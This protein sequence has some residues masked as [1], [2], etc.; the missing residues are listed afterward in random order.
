MVTFD[1]TLP[2]SIAPTSLSTTSIFFL[3]SISLTDPLDIQCVLILFTP[4]APPLPPQCP[5]S[6]H[7]GILLSVLPAGNHRDSEFLSEMAV[8]CPGDGIS[9]GSSL[10]PPELSGG[11][12]S[13]ARFPSLGWGVFD[14]EDTLRAECSA[15][16]YPQLLSQLQDTGQLLTTG[17]RTASGQC[18]EQYRSMV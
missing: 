16:A 4:I 17:G 18:C 6:H 13:S 8:L 9:R 5:L 7:H 2:N 10:L 3:L 14:G 11:A 1:K 12:P 15:L